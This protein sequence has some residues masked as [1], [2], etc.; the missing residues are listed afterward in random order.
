MDLGVE[1]VDFF[2]LV[3]V[4]L[5]LGSQLDNGNRSAIKSILLF[6]TKDE[7]TGIA[8]TKPPAT[9]VVAAFKQ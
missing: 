7:E 8:T 4:L 9:M 6:I 2:P 3:M 1:L 5:L